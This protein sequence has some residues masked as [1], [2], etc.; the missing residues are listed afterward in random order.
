MIK[1]DHKSL[2]NLLIQT[3]QTSKQQ[4][5]LCKLLG[6]DF[7]YI[8]KPGP[9]NKVADALSRAHDN[10]DGEEIIFLNSSEDTSGSLLDC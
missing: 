9:E 10:D 8:Y 1:I 5:F 3:I 7:S 6:F 2:K 4:I